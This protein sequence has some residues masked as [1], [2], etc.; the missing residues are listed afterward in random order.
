MQ[1]GEL[2]LERKDLDAALLHFTAAQQLEPKNPRATAGL[3]AVTAGKS[4]LSALRERFE[5]ALKDKDLPAAEEQIAAMRQLAPG[6]PTLVL[7]E[8]ELGNSKLT[9]QTKAKAAADQE[10]AIVAQAKALS[11]L[12]DDPTQQIPAVEQALAGFVQRAGA[13]R[14]ERKTLETKLEDRRQ[15]V[16]LTQSLAGLDAALTRKDAAAIKAA[17]SDATFAQDLITLTGYEGLVFESRLADFAR[18][19]RTAKATVQVR[20]ALKVFPERTLTL[21]YDLTNA[22][23]KGWIIAGAKLV[24]P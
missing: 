20:H 14:P 23:G 7:A 2:A 17:V 8:N 4:K 12:I 16:V 6:S 18:S 5:Q 11:A 24:R 13:D 3:D 15:R 1:Q 10:A 21:V 22:D 19:E 9:E